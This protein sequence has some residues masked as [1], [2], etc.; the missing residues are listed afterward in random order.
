L[1]R[2]DGYEYKFELNP[3]D[4]S[5]GIYYSRKE[6][7][8]EEWTNAN[9][10]TSDEGNV[11]KA[12]IANLFGHSDF[13]DEKREQ[14]FSQVEGQ[15]QQE[16]DRKEAVLKYKADNEL[17]WHGMITGGDGLQL[18]DIIDTDN[19]W[20]VGQEDFNFFA[21]DAKWGEA[22]ARAS[23]EGVEALIDGVDAY[24]DFVLEPIAGALN[25]AGILDFSDYEDD[26]WDGISFDNVVNDIVTEF[27]IG[28][29]GK[30]GAYGE[31][32]DFGEEV[33]DL[34]ESG[35]LNIGMGLMAA[36][37]LLADTKKVIGDSLGEILPQGAQDFLNST[38]MK[39]LRN[40]TGE[41]ALDFITQKDLVEG[42]EKAYDVY[43]KKAN[44][45]NQ[46]LFDFNKVGM[47]ETL[48]KAFDGDLT[49]KERLAAWVTGSS[50]ITAAALGSL[51]SV[52]Q[53]M[54]PYVGIA[55][56]VVGEAAKTNMES[57]KD[58][59]PLGWDRIG[60][61]YVIGASEGL[62][63]LVTKKI[64]KGMFQGLRGGGKEVIKKS[65][66]QHATKVLKEFGQEGLSETATLMIN[67]AA[68]Y[69]YKDEVKN[70]IPAW[71]EIMDT[72][73]IGGVMGG[74]MS[75]AGSGAQVLRSTI[76]S[77]RIGTNLKQSGYTSLSGM[78]DLSSEA[79]TGME[80]STTKRPPNEEGP[81]DQ[82]SGPIRDAKETSTPV[83]DTVKG[84]ESIEDQKIESKKSKTLEDEV[85]ETETQV[86]EKGNRQATI[87]KSDAE[88][89]V[90]SDSLDTSRNY[91]KESNQK[92]DSKPKLTLDDKAN[93]RTKILEN[94]Q[95]EMFLNTELK[96]KVDNGE[97]T[98]T[99]SDEIK[100]N[101][102][103]QQGAN[104]QLNATALTGQARAEAIDLLAEAEVL[105]GK[106]KTGGN[107]ALTEGASNRIK[108][109]DQ[110]LK[111]IQTQNLTPE[112]L[113]EYK[114]KINKKVENEVAL[115]KKYGKGKVKSF[116]TSAEFME[117]TGETDP[118]VDAYVDAKTGE[119]FINKQHMREAGAV[120]VGRHELLHK[121]LK[122]E[123]SDI[124]NGEKLKEEFLEILKK[125]D[126][127][128]HSLLISRMEQID[129]ETG[130]R[131]YP[132]E[133]LERNP[134]EYLAIF[135]SLVAE[136]RIT[137]ESIVE[138]PTLIKKLSDFFSKIFSNAANENPTGQD[139]K[140]SDIGF[141]DGQ[142]LYDFIKTYNKNTESGIISDRAQKL[143]DEGD[144]LK[145]TD[146]KTSKTVS[147]DS[148]DL[149]Q[150]IKELVPSDVKT[151]QDFFNP[152]VFNKIFSINPNT[153]KG[154]LNPLI[155]AYVITKSTSPE[156]VTLNLKNIADR[157]LNFDPAKKRA[158]GKIVGPEGFAE[159][160]TSN[161]NF[162][163]R[164][165]N[166]ELFKKGE[167]E[168]QEKSIDDSTL[169]MPG[170]LNAKS[171]LND[172]AE[173]KLVDA[174][175]L[176]FL[177][178]GDGKNMPLLIAA[179]ESDQKGRDFSKDNFK[180]IKPGKQLADAWGKVFGL[181][182]KLL[183][184]MG[185]KGGKQQEVSAAE[186][187]K[188]KENEA[189][190][191]LRT[192][193]NKNAQEVIELLPDA[194]DDLGK[195]TGI[196]GNVKE[197]FY[198]TNSDGKLVKRKDIRIKEIADAMKSPDDA[199]LY[200]SKQAQTIKGINKIIFQQLAN[201]VA[202]SNI[203]D[204]TQKQRMGSG[205]GKKVYSK[206]ITSLQNT[207]LT[208]VS[209][210]NGIDNLAIY[211]KDKG[212]LKGDITATDSN[213]KARQ[214]SV[215]QSI[216]KGNIPA[217]AIN[218]LGLGNFGAKRTEAKNGDYYY[219]L[220][221]GKTIIG[222]PTL[223]KDGK[224]R[225][226][227]KREDGT[228]PKLYTLPTLQ[229]IE[230]AYPG[231]NVKIQAAKG[232]LYY[233]KT[234]PAYIEMMRVADANNSLYSSE[235]IDN[236]KNVG[237]III[238]R[239]TKLTRKQKKANKAQEEINQKAL[240]DF[241]KILDKGVQN[242]TIPLNDA[243]L[244]ISQ[245]YQGTTSLIKISA[246]FVGVSDVFVKAPKGTKQA[247]RY[248]DYIEEHSPPASKVGL[249][250]IYGLATNTVTP[251]MK[252]V[253]DNFVQ[254][255]LSNS[256]DVL[257]DK[258]KL[259]ARFADGTNILTP[260]AGFL[261]LAAADINLN[262][263]QDLNT[264]LDIATT[265][266]YPL[267]GKFKTDPNS[268][269][270]QKKLMLEQ[271]TDPNMKFSRSVGR[272]NTYVNNLGES[273]IGASKNNASL[274]PGKVD[275]NMSMDQ[276]IEVLENYD[277]TL[278][279]SK[280]LN[281]KPKGISV[282]DFD[283]TLARTKEKVIVTSAD[284]NIKEISA[285]QFAEQASDLQDDGATFDFT[286]FENVSK[287]TQ[288]GPLAD[289]AL[290]RQGKFGSKDIFVLTARPQIAATGIKTFLDGIGLNLPLENITG[291]ENGS[292]QA[293]ANW[294]V[295]KTAEGYND[296]YFADDAI[297]NVKAV[298]EILDQVDVKSK[299]QQAKFSKSLNF[300]KIMND[301]IE[302]ATGI[303][304][305]KEY[306]PAR[307]KTVGA[308]KGKYSFF[309]TPS[310]EDFLGLI[311]K[312]LG[313]GK[314]GDA[315]MA[316][317]KDNV[318]D[319]Y[320]RAET[321][322]IRAK[323]S[324]ANDFKALKNKLKTLPKSLSK[325]TGI[326]GF[327]F[328]QAVRVAIWTR[329]G[330][331]IPG[332]SK[333]DVK[334]L[335]DFVDNNAELDVFADELI[336]MQKGKPYPKAGENWLAGTIVSDIINDIN[337]T[338]RKE[339]LQEWQENVDIIFS[340]KNLAKLEAAYGPRYVEALRDQLARMKS[341]SN[342]PIGGSRIVNNLLDWLNNSVGAI[343]FLNTRSAVLQTISAVNFINWGD[344][345]IVAAGKAFANQKQYWKDFMTLMNSP[346]LVDRR[347]GLKINVSES[348]I[349]DA[350]SESTNKPKAFLNLLLSKGFVLTR[351]ADSFAIAS[352][353]A[354]FFRNRV[355]SLIKQGM[356][357]KDAE[358]QAFQDF[359]AIAETSQQSS[360]P[361]KISQQQASGAGRVILAFANTPMQY[362]RII[363]RSTQDL[364]N[365]RGD[366]RSNMSKIVYYAAI[367][368]LMFNALQTALFALA[369][370][371][372]EEETD[373]ARQ[374]KIDDKTGRIANGM[375]DS[376]IRGLG[377][378]GAAVVALKDAI[379][380]IARENDKDG[381]P[382]F[383]KAI[384]DLFGFSPPLDA[385]LRKLKSAANTL[386]WD[387]KRMEEE[388]FGLNNPAYLAGAQVVSAL[389]NIPLD[390]A[391]QKINNLRAIVSDSSEKWQKVALSLGWG[392]WDVGLPYYGV[393][394]KEI[395]T[396]Q[397]ILRDKVLKMKKDTSVVE[398]KQMLL[399]LGLTKQQIKALKYEEVRIKKIIELQNKK[400]K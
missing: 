397:T 88:A 255:Q 106:I 174:R 70:W 299:V 54:V 278:K 128:A 280:S 119:I 383:A 32:Y 213:R 57:A 203:K 50:R 279:F 149:F 248:L 49:G 193:I 257:L 114:D 334:Q 113:Q 118:N 140:P 91:K 250:I 376:L 320:N 400:L 157:L 141:K 304:S 344:N 5:Q 77:K 273:V 61:A 398:Q 233:G 382:D 17:G 294:V 311:Y 144:G 159:F 328:G 154:E 364:I 244:F 262:T 282:F 275:T 321:A 7:S 201:V 212:L 367:Q 210:L 211:L 122:S 27:A 177:E 132:P 206:T 303:E 387:Q 1:S 269:S 312:L 102:K 121:I 129:P 100:A 380:T 284:G 391:I 371:D 242:K 291:L 348:E 164:D 377:I 375:F 92:V 155:K 293:K 156:Q 351:F 287:G 261:R 239:N 359:Y 80:D 101:F 115:A 316:F 340:E 109:I 69:V 308:N 160:I 3:E 330:M 152:R 214:D 63:E 134:D 167:K 23:G 123:F 138:K 301:V 71:G 188:E 72:F 252:G 25:Y 12:S 8:K 15:K 336:K 295:S 85:A 341:G 302:G 111:Q 329:Q 117:A 58:G 189:F 309:T 185:M 28:D 99:K 369:F 326:G 125:E 399:D 271:A 356:S 207:Q 75:F 105:D 82:G 187:I 84:Q 374:K 64:G 296:F 197:L 29:G 6:G 31:S 161:T 260:N 230:A 246:P 266:G 333:R 310:A 332:L 146:K 108:E 390:R 14:Y 73:L 147:E 247:K 66:L 104:N 226:G 179:I 360:N 297:G 62:L 13:D 107:A 368:N 357:K 183:F 186:N 384:F 388:G 36:P 251:I 2:G 339:Y 298:K 170:D 353:G 76:N 110:R 171:N 327:T 10:N 288:K 243:A 281:T 317:F 93:K 325:Q 286:N 342:R 318:I 41:V 223:D 209:S 394:D 181:N 396:P 26:S 175:K 392:T 182:P 235:V 258:A 338:N 44:Q 37:K 59:R 162:S 87:K 178:D 18:S 112:Q 39:A 225:Y 142:D 11:A 314:V 52:V 43:S 126:P 198:T 231:Q 81:D 22:I 120:G 216:I 335:N 283:D 305:Y 30:A 176:Q 290:R 74:G 24:A 264:G 315:Q 373:E 47:T 137:Q 20:K 158:D 263:I 229:S 237:R 307:A 362:A 60:H 218:L 324:A 254:V 94:P 90:E 379:M 143:M 215:L 89:V 370:D 306:S 378:Q 256:S 96:R 249:S 68:D 240:A 38:A 277:K 127:D 204:A 350:V 34:V 9:D 202:R 393:E 345:N 219:T 313:K 300:D 236:F 103:R 389:T 48:G 238:P 358:A 130:D 385:K 67:Q 95:A 136:G 270:I 227:K 346:Y 78:F 195:A 323:T 83:Q 46:T 168:K 395:Q 267:K 184:A 217:A 200:R 56:I 35:M 45:L 331:T 245:A 139:V 172:K 153:N 363:K 205:R 253:K 381:S 148:K 259:G 145:S 124:E 265:M 208:E 221:N 386:S 224:Q 53:S 347:D 372:E 322:L 4:K 232:S 199:K 42:G 361:S 196:P 337:K 366:W 79:I 319:P 191:T 194:Y 135:S 268:V 150:K 40:M 285:A 169:Q 86:N 222:T 355:N 365:G 276:Q 98:T 151:Q 166:K 352:G 55:S 163:Q 173:K 220:D 190:R 354:T 131:L 274:F 228:R 51:P 180:S 19:W 241:V 133:Y 289:L 343:M 116:E 234:D 33:G 21:D 292:P 16:I 165:S 349:A 97:I 65:L 272:L 192:F